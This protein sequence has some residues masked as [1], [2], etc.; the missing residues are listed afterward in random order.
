MPARITSDKIINPN[1]YYIYFTT[2]GLRSRYRIDPTEIYLS[3]SEYS[4]FLSL[5]H[6]PK[7]STIGT[8][9]GICY[10]PKNFRIDVNS[11]KR[12]KVL[13]CGHTFH[14]SC[15]TPWFESHGTCPICRSQ[16]SSITNLS[17]GGS[18]INKYKKYKH[19]YLKLKE[20]KQI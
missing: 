20:S 13:S 9:C 11:E 15:I 16:I 8:E 17:L 4:L 19:K 6:I 14:N 12:I 10:E 3:D 5:Y 2:C 7:K 18:S 1:E